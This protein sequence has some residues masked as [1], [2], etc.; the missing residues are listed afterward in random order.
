MIP[1]GDGWLGIDWFSDQP[2]YEKCL[3]VCEREKID[4]KQ[5]PCDRLFNKINKEK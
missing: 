3:K 4:L 2:T 1:T 5:C